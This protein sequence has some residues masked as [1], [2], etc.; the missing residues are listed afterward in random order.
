MLEMGLRTL[1]VSG[2]II[3]L[4]GMVIAFQTAYQMR[5]LGGDVLIPGLVAVSITRELGP[6]M[7]ALVI[8]GRVGAAVTA[9]LGTMAVT[10]QVDAIA[11]SGVPPVKYLVAPRFLAMALMV[12][13]L[14]VYTDAIGV[15]G[16]YVVATGKLGLSHA[17]YFDAV[18]KALVLSD[19]FSGLAKSFIF[20]MVVCVVACFE[21]LRVSGGAEGVGRSTMRCVVTSFLLIVFADFVF[22]IVFYIAPS[23]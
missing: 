5:E 6:V 13:V 23:P 17:Y 1:P 9:E 19:V 10:E 12:P 8:A 3:F 22:T 11:V 15:L 18:F 20:A 14:T 7:T 16:G 21:G 2:V 4:L